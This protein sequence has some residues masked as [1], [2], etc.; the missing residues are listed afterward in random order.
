M[1]AR[2]WSKQLEQFV[3]NILLTV[4]GKI[5]KED[6]IKKDHYTVENDDDYILQLFTGEFDRNNKEIFQGDIV[7]VPANFGGDC[8]YELTFAEVVFE[9]AEFVLR[10]LKNKD[11]IVFQDWN[12]NC[13]EVVDNIL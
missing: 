3:Y 4:D 9:N 10:D 11:G 8:H 5:V 2:V 12:W 1:K 7:V 6:K 13:L